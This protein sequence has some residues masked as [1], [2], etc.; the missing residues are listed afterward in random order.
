MTETLDF[1]LERVNSALITRDFQYAEQML[2]NALKKHPNL[3][4]KNKEKIE[5]LFARVYCDAGDLEKALEAYLRLYEQKPNDPAVMNNLGRIYRHLNRFDDA[6]A[7]LEKSK[8]I[9][10]LTDEVL[11][12]L[13]KT[14]K[15]MHNYE[16]AAEYFSLAIEIKPD[17][18][19]AYDRLG[20]L[21]VLTGEKNKAIEAYKN[22]LRVDSNHPYLNFHLA[23][24]LREDKRY[25]EAI[26][27]YNSALRTNPSWSEVLN[28]I[29][30]TYLQLDKLDDALNTYRSLLRVAGE[31]API[32]TE[33]G[34]LFEKKRLEAEA[35]QHYR[36]ALTIDNG[37][38]PAAIAL[39]K[40]LEKQK[41][42]EEVLTVLLAAEAA[43]VNKDNHDLR[44]KAIE[45]SIYAKDYAK[46]HELIKKVDKQYANDITV[47]KLKGQLSALT[48][49][50][51][52]AEVTFEKILQLSPSAIEFRRELAE[53]Y[54][55]AHRYKEAKDQLKLFLRQKP[56]DISAL[57]DLGKTEELLNNHK[58]A[59]QTYQNVLEQ[60]P[61]TI[62]A[63]SALARL[64][65]KHGNTIEALQ[66][67]DEI[68]NLQSTGK[69]E[70]HIQGIAEA[71]D[72]YES[73]AQNYMTDPLLTKNLE[74]L[75]P[76]D[77]E[78]YIPPTELEQRN[79][80]HDIFPLFEE[81]IED[82]EDLPFELLVEK[83]E[84]DKPHDDDDESFENIQLNM[85]V[86]DKTVTT[87]HFTSVQEA[88]A[89]HNSSAI[90]HT[91]SD[92]PSAYGN[93]PQ[94][95]SDV[96]RSYPDVPQ[97]YTEQRSPQYSSISSDAGAFSSLRHA[98]DSVSPLHTEDLL[99]EPETP[100]TAPVFDPSELSK[101]L[102]RPPKF[103]GK[104]AGTQAAESRLANLDTYDTAVEFLRDIAPDLIQEFDAKRY[105]QVIEKLA[106]KIAENLAGRVHFPQRSEADTPIG[107]EQVK[108]ND[109]VEL[110]VSDILADAVAGIHAVEDSQAAAP[111]LSEDEAPKDV[112]LITEFTEDNEFDPVYEFESLTAADEMHQDNNEQPLP[113]EAQVEMVLTEPE[114]PLASFEGYAEEDFVENNEYDLSDEPSGWAEDNDVLHLDGSSVESTEAEPADAEPFTLDK[115]QQNL[116]WCHAKRK[117]KDSPIFEECLSAT[118]SEELAQLL[119]YL[120]DLLAF[121]PQD[122]LNLFLHSTER[123]LTYYIISRLSGEL[124]LKDRADLIHQS[125]GGVTP[126]SAGKTLSELLEYLRELSADLPD[127]GIGERCRQE[128]GHLIIHLSSVMTA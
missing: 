42:Y 27:Y 106:E 124:G 51:T 102:L 60:A 48:G 1:I 32:Y 82:D 13:A 47:L 100:E 81:V 76:E 29:A 56:A 84:E 105:T 117:L 66:T 3:S 74:Q 46:A 24:L 26:I 40:L 58:A 83:A 61:N 92:F 93:V 101:I 70:K 87:P 34:L 18:A 20:N 108:T 44:L 62:E 89:L 23:A 55:L 122:K 53:Q 91:Y 16:K 41:A 64:F 54:L 86:E 19:H 75:K 107:M 112:E 36:K 85:G 115:D 59:Y 120:R 88:A 125:F 77:E 5:E 79:S 127:K 15:R 14:Y 28:D 113:A 38:A 21:Y 98:N 111:M 71:L 39:S 33:I 7:I 114:K 52:E 9:G 121:L 126:S 4:L 97:A 99:L 110:P 12:N 50:L 45:C 96:P 90:P 67:A 25:E 22:G 123:M 10:G 49:N 2:T 119:L 65:Q 17:H 35:E 72:L 116:L 104:T 80:Q 37:Y 31:S 57:M 30:K 43:P 6:L 69:D 63:R 128:L 78:V 94:A 8:E 109:T 103:S 73:A 68:L 118:D 95:Y 11:Y